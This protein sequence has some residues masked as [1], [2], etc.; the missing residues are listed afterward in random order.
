[1]AKTAAKTITAEAPKSKHDDGK[2]YKLYTVGTGHEVYLGPGVP[3]DRAEELARMLVD[4]PEIRL[5]TAD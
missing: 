4:T 5:V 1:M 2:R 3:L